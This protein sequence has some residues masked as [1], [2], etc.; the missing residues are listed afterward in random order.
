VIPF[1]TPASTNF[2]GAKKQ[3]WDTEKDDIEF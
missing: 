2:D 1:K 3:W